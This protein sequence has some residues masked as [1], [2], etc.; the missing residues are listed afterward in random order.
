[1]SIFK[2]NRNLLRFLRVARVFYSFTENLI[3]KFTYL[4]RQSEGGRGGG[5]GRGIVEEVNRLSAQLDIDC[6]RYG[7]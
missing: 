7:E 4:A 6:H 5:K 3:S 1:M 2:L